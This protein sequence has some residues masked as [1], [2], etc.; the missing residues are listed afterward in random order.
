LISEIKRCR[1]CGKVYVP[2]TALWIDEDTYLEPDLI[3]LSAKLEAEMSPKHWTRADIV[4]EVIS[5]ANANYDR[6][7]KSDTYRAM[8][9]RELLLIDNETKQVEVRSFESNVNTVYS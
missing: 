1:Y 9:I 4:V 6:T 2:R 5:P 3:Y 7:T 8:G